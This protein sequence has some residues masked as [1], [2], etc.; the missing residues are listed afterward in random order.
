[1]KSICWVIIFSLFLISCDKQAGPGG[2]SSLVGK[3][4]VKEYDETMSILKAEYYAQDE[5][6]YLVYGDNTIYSDKFSTG[7]DGSFTFNF[8]K[9]GKYKVF[10]YSADS[11]G[12]SSTGT[13]PLY[14]EIE[15]NKN[16]KT[17]DFGEITIIKTSKFNNGT[18]T[19][20]GR[21]FCRDYNTDFSLLLS[22]YYIPDQDVFLVQGNDQYYSDDLKTDID[23]WYR[24][25]KVPL[26]HYTVYALS[27]DSTFT[28]PS[29]YVAS[30]REIDITSNYQQV[31]LDD[32]IILK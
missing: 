30:E 18:S 6:V 5:D 25:E 17:F 9:K 12:S 32:I 24:F 10:V 14:S 3:I 11:T 29:G 7:P 13:V 23:G 22:Q 26:G 1:M 28:S 8:L 20:S 2:T 27:K 4:K 31:V 16:N 21:I 15:I 19:I